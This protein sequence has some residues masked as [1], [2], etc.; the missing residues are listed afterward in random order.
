MI[1]RARFPSYARAQTSLNQLNTFAFACM[2]WSQI[3]LSTL[4]LRVATLS[5]ASRSDFTPSQPPD[6]SSFQNFNTGSG[7]RAFKLSHTPVSSLGYTTPNGSKDLTCQSCHK[8]FEFKNSFRRHLKSCKLKAGL[9]RKRKLMFTTPNAKRKK[10]DLFDQLSSSSSDTDSDGCVPEVGKWF[11]TQY[12]FACS[13]VV[14]RQI[15]F[16]LVI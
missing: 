5:M 13:V 10:S 3:W 14:D 4:V 12:S 2:I 15:S 8:G 7:V 11:M 16:S 6:P 9:Q 1:S